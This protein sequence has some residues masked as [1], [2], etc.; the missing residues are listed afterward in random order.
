MFRP[1]ES[2]S[3]QRRA[4][5]QASAAGI[6]SDDRGYVTSVGLACRDASPAPAMPEQVDNS[7]VQSDSNHYR[8]WNGYVPKSIQNGRPRECENGRPK[9][10]EA[11][12]FRAGEVPCVAQDNRCQHSVE[13]GSHHT[14][15][16][17]QSGGCHCFPEDAHNGTPRQR[18]LPTGWTPRRPLRLVT[19]IL[20][21]PLPARPA[22]AR[23]GP[24]VASLGRSDGTASSDR[25]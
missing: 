12:V 22:S 1:T 3:T 25:R 10:I 11:M 14:V 24:R 15:P 21:W 2:L 17:R 5:R 23:R 18:L 20:P 16:R 4:P 13:R 8:R 7:G 6:S 19:I 9:P